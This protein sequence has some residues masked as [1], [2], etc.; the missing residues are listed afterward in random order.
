MFFNKLSPAKLIIIFT[1][2]LG[3]FS[4]QISYCVNIIFDLG[5]VLILHD[6]KNIAKN[7]NKNALALYLI[8]L[9][10]PTKLQKRIF[11]LLEKLPNSYKNAYQNAG[12]NTCPNAYQNAIA[13]EDDKGQK[14]PTIMCDW[15]AGKVLSSDI[16]DLC[17][18]FSENNPSF[19]S[20]GEK[21]ILLNTLELMF[22]PKI[23]IES[24]KISHDC[25]KFIKICKK[26]GHKLFIL[27][28]WDLQSC[29]L[30]LE[31]YPEIFELFDPENIIFS[32]Q[33]GLIKPDPKIFNFIIE[34]YNL[35][36]Q[37]CIFFDDQNVN[38][39]SAQNCGIKGILCKNLGYNQM[40]KK[41]NNFVLDCANNNNLCQKFQNL[42]FD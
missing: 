20:L 12:Q 15:L 14:L 8:T 18:K 24:C 21:S 41:L 13:A 38:I 39:F 30:L 25:L 17:Y 3:H 10:N 37:E 28:N 31:K 7:L 1:L 2:I 5:G 35:N 42:L 19:F 40:V 6:K 32:G 26:A 11:E 27:S 36:P 29:S 33:I 34:K 23:F 22:D 9:N 16:V 4:C